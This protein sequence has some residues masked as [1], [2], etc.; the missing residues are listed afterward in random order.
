MFKR[1][2]DVLK[3]PWRVAP[4][5]AVAELATCAKRGE[6]DGVLSV[7]AAYMRVGELFGR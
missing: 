3:I 7:S 1:M 5:S 6:I 4:G 2:L